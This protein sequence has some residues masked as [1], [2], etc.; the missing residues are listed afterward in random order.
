MGKRIKAYQETVIGDATASDLL[1]KLVD[2]KA[3]PAR[4]IYNAIL[5]F[6]APRHPEFAGN[7]LWSLYNSVT[8]NLKNGDLTKLPAR[9]MVM[10]SV[11]DR[12]AH[13]DSI[14]E[15]DAEILVA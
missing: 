9:T 1:V 14:I 6:R 2:S 13:H 7:S 10:Q 8:E 15:I 5:E 3:F 11:F 4:D 12:V